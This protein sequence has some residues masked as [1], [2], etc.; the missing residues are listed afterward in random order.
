METLPDNEQDWKARFRILEARAAIWRGTSD[1]ALQAL[2]FPDPSSASP[3]IK[4]EHHALLAQAYS[5]LNQFDAAEKQLSVGES[6]CAAKRIESCGELIR[7]RAGLAIQRGQID[8]ARRY[9]AQCLEWSQH[10]GNRFEEAASFMNLGGVSLMQEHFDDAIDWLNASDK[11][12]ET[13]DAGDIL[14][15]NLGNLGWAHYKLGEP[16]VALALYAKAQSRAVALGDLDDAIVWLS[17]ASLAYHDTGDLNRARDSLQRAYQLSEKTGDKQNIV[18]ALEGLAYVSL[19]AG[20]L[21]RSEQYLNLLAPL[22]DAGDNRLDKL[23]V[24]IARGRLAAEQHQNSA[25]EAIFHQVISD[26]N[27]QTSMRL[28][29]QYELARLY[30][31]S[32]DGS[33]TRQAF[34]A[35]L[36]IFESA[37][38]QLQRE[39]SKLPFLANAAGIYDSYIHFLIEKGETAE[40]LS[41]ADQSRAR[42]LE[43]GLGIDTSAKSASLSAVHSLDASAIARRAHATLLFYWLGATQSYLWVATPAETA[44]F[45]LPPRAKIADLVA[46]YRR[47]LLGPEDTASSTTG[48]GEAL[49]R[50]LIAPAASIIPHDG[51]VVILGDGAL[52]LLNF[53]TLVVPG[54]PSHFYIEDATL[55]SAPSLQLLLASTERPDATGGKLLLIGDAISDDPNYPQL[56]M[57]MREMHEVESHFAAGARTVLAEKSATPD[58]YLASHPAQYGYIHFVAHGTASSTDPLESAI[59]LSPNSGKANGNFKLYAREITQHHIRARLVTVSACYGSG[60]RSYAGEGLVGLSWAFLRAGAHNVIGAL[61]EV[62]DTSTPQLMNSLYGGL[63]VGQSPAQALRQAKLTLLHSKGNFKQPFYWAPFEIYTGL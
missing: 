15:N 23:A 60:D 13:L 43:Q 31:T 1:E 57:A 41:V 10:Y 8:D 39:D 21:K 4:I 63:A 55:T 25:A 62:S 22:I 14:V 16:R 11:I 30:E 20:D 28:E 12:A 61:W 49:Y 5:H 42:T 18:N 33:R 38:N 50:M 35:A 46:R 32:G 52:N 47:E 34:Q 48:D 9:F 44:F 27:S 36:S 7:A 45:T 56:P 58:A 29:A 26:P 59:I 53:E 3:T 24:A 54:S 17:T 37:R 19:D 6:L 40:A 51:N 2:T